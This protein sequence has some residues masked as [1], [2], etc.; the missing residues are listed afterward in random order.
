MFLSPFLFPV[1]VEPDFKQRRRF[2]SPSIDRAIKSHSTLGANYIEKFN[3]TMME[4]F[5]EHQRQ[6]QSNFQRWE[7]ERQRQHEMSME[8]WR[9]QSRD[10]EKQMFGMFVR[11]RRSY[12]QLIVLCIHFKKWLLNLLERHF[13]SDFFSQCRKLPICCGVYSCAHHRNISISMVHTGLSLKLE[14]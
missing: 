10:H 14:D 7:M 5:M 12:F 13:I 11:V 9:Q 2:G 6:I 4:Q 8:R 3:Q 1:V